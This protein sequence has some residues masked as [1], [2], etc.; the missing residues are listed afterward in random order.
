MQVSNAVLSPCFAFMPQLTNHDSPVA[1][2]ARSL[3]DSSQY[4]VRKWGFVRF[5]S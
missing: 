4:A 3:P 2:V 1:M 5:P